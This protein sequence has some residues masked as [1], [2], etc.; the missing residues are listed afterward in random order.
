MYS[1]LGGAGHLA[2]AIAAA[3]EAGDSAV[4][5]LG[6][7][8]VGHHLRGSAG[9]LEALVFQRLDEVGDGLC[10][11]L[12]QKH[13]ERVAKLDAAELSSIC[14]A[15]TVPGATDTI[16]GPPPPGTLCEL[17]GS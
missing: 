8:C 14:H 9:N 11:V 1:I 15:S 7:Q 6:A 12:E 10:A 16:G 3:F 4:R 13:G 2:G 17:P 5:D